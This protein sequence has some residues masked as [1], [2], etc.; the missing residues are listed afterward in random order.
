MRTLLYL[1]LALLIAG[2]AHRPDP[3]QRQLDEARRLLRSAPAEA[4]EQLNAMDISQWRDTA[5][6]AE[7]AMLYSEAMAANRL[8]CPTDT[9]INIAIDYYAARRSTP[10]WQRAT[11][12]RHL[13]F[14]PQAGATDRLATARY[15]QKEKEFFLYKETVRRERTML[16]SGL[17]L[18]LAGGIILVQRQRLRLR[19]TQCDALM[20]EAS[21]LKGQID[22]GLTDT[23]RLHAAL[24]TALAQRFALIDSLCATYY[25]TQG[26]RAERKAVADRVR[27]EIEAMQT[28][29]R[30]HDDIMRAVN[31]CRDGLLTRLQTALPGLTPA[32]LR[33]LTYLACGLSARTASLLLGVSIDTFYKRKSRLKLRIRQLGMPG[34][35]EFLSLFS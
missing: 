24:H 6:L 23:T 3:T 7:W 21:C 19:A 16:L 8:S 10:Q 17:A 34:A 29:S 1:F 15:L 27:C 2:C 30:A 35:D 31:D 28:D 26:T 18:L 14:A 32:D 11:R 22:A 12:L 20:A 5:V 9:I 33:L 25:E 4:F 13:V